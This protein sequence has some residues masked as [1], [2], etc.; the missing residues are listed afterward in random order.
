MSPLALKDVASKADPKAAAEL[1][2]E[3]ADVAALDAEVAADDADVAAEDAEVDAEEA[4]VAADVA[5]V[6]VIAVCTIC[7]SVT[8]IFLLID[9]PKCLSIVSIYKKMFRIIYK[10]HH[11][12]YNTIQYNL[13]P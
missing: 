9:T 8:L 4:L 13:V 5:D 6:E 7:S 10:N 2:A 11:F 1:A 12:V 3:V